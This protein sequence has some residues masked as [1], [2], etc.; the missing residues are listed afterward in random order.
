MIFFG[1]APSP[2]LL[3]IR[4]FVLVSCWCVVALAFLSKLAIAQE[5]TATLTGTF[6]DEKGN[7]IHGLSVA[8]VNLSTGNR[9][10]LETKAD[11]TFRATSLA[12]SAYSIEAERAGLTRLEFKVEIV[13]SGQVLDVGTLVVSPTPTDALPSTTAPIPSSPPVQSTK[14]IDPVYEE[15]TVTARRVEE[16]V[17]SVP[18]PISVISGPVIEKAAAFNINRLKELIPTVQ[19]YSSNPRNSSVN[20]R[21]L[22]APFGLT[23]DGIEPGVGFYVD[24]VFYARS[25]AATLDFLDLERIEI[26]RGPQGTLFGKNTTA[27]AI[28]I[29][30]RR[31][32]FTPEANF[33]V[34][35]GNYGFVQ[36]KGSISGPLSKKLAAR[37][38][39]SG[40]QRDGLL[41]NTR[42]QDDVNDLNNLGFRTQFLYTP[43]DKM[44]ILLSGDYTRQRPEGYA[45]LVTGVAPTLRP[46]NRQ[47][48]G[49]ASDLRYA[50]PS[51][52]AFDRLIDT[53]TPWRSNQ[54]M[55][56]GAV[57]LDWTLGKGQLTSIT[58][59]RYWLWRPSNDRDFVGLPITTVS[60]APSRQRQWTQEVRYAATVNPRVNYLIGAFLFQ[61][62]LNP[63]PFHKQEQGSAAARYLLAPSAAAATPGLLDGYGQNIDFNFRNFSGAVFGQVEYSLT[64][65]LRVIP[66]LRFNHDQKKLDYDQQ[67]YGGLQTTD[68][69]LIALQ[70]S[71]LAP[72]AYKA[73]IGDNNVSGQLTLSYK[74]GE[75]A[76]AYGTFAT[77]FKSIGLNLGGVPTDAAGNPIVS[78]AMVRP[79]SVRH[80]EVGVKTRP[81]TGLTVNVTAFNTGIRDFQT[82]VVNAQVGVLRG[83]LANAEKVRV[84]GIELDTTYRATENLNLY[85]SGAFADGRYMTFRDAPPPLEETGG[86]QA[87]DIS[88]SILPGISKWAASFG[89]EWTKNTSFLGQRGEAFARIDASYRSSFSSNPSFS[90]YLVVDSYILINPRVGFRTPDGWAIA[91]W[92]RNVG[93][94]DY[95]E[96]L[97]AAPGSSGLFVG[98]PGDPR[99]F[100]VTLSKSFSFKNS[101]LNGGTSA[102][103]TAAHPKSSDRKAEASVAFENFDKQR[104]GY[105]QSSSDSESAARYL[106]VR[107]GQWVTYGPSSLDPKGN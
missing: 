40:T 68:P 29:T 54:D 105:Q 96:F 101:G 42:T 35:F 91:V 12:P 2:S 13:Q 20:I 82:Q 69:T 15:V 88:G 25:A 36:A 66:G 93:N 90:R 57:E 95:F 48:P 75:N 76:N 60:A 102:K 44:V 71:V 1:V 87:K 41:Y 3:N 8:V 77:G 72:L 33:E 81:L 52:N 78:A 70:R 50:P 98:L 86:P 47:W 59:W 21:G 80:F 92:A 5:Q 24:G 99:T 11:G 28:N 22:G 19:F 73:D 26:L 4:K 7:F 67:V 62:I 17:Q 83:Y 64:N 94:K 51:Y 49:I 53:D 58:A 6:K 103:A 37:L 63:A 27:G 16:E 45:Q 9:T 61:Q 104:K 79:E 85:A 31:P 56:G 74:L 39:F 100:G 46:A 38:S 84:R 97:S 23:N 107:P 30:T 106:P 55:G 14:P 89:G 32:S 10:T 65:R 43:T 34:S 18:I